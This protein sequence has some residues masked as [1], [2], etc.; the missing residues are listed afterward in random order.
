MPP[1][2]GATTGRLMSMNSGFIP[3]LCEKEALNTIPVLFKCCVMLSNEVM[4][5]SD[6]M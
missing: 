3:Y 4:L 2:D 1:W 5:C 6:K